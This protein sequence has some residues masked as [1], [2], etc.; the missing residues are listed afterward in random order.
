MTAHHC[1]CGCVAALLGS[2]IKYLQKC[3][4]G[5]PEEVNSSSW[6]SNVSDEEVVSRRENITMHLQITAVNHLPSAR[7]DPIKPNCLAHIRVF[8]AG[9]K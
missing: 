6:F 5:R 8:Q 9:N 2:A 4:Q 7:G 3:G 1:L